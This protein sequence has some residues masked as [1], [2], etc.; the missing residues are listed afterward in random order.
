MWVNLL[1]IFHVT[2][3][4]YEGITVRGYCIWTHVSFVR[5]IFRQE[6]AEMFRKICA[7]VHILSV[8]IF[9]YTNA[10]MGENW[11]ISSGYISPVSLTYC[12]VANKDLC[13]RQADIIGRLL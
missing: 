3:E 8:Y 10:L 5:K 11:P 2:D 1:Y 7:C 12:S 6:L 9:G 4:L 13:P